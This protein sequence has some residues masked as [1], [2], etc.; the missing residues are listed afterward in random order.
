MAIGVG[1]EWRK[2]KNVVKKGVN[3]IGIIVVG[4]DWTAAPWRLAVEV[5]EAVNLC[6]PGT[7]WER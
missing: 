3:N 5:V 7:T 2:R 1:V 4:R 6:K